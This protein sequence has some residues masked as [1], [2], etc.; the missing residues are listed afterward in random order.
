MASMISME[1]F[2]KCA[3]LAANGCD[4][5]PFLRLTPLLETVEYD[6]QRVYLFVSSTIGVPKTIDEAENL[7]RKRLVALTEKFGECLRLIDRPKMLDMRFLKEIEHQLPADIHRMFWKPWKDAR[8][9][10][11]PAQLQYELADII[12]IPWGAEFT[13]ERVGKKE[14]IK[15]LHFS[16]EATQLL[17]DLSQCG[18]CA[19]RLICTVQTGFLQEPHGPIERLMDYFSN[20]PDL[21]IKGQWAHKKAYRFNSENDWN[22]LEPITLQ[23][24]CSGRFSHLA[25]RYPNWDSQ[26]GIPDRMDAELLSDPSQAIV[27]ATSA[28]QIISEPIKT[29]SSPDGLRKVRLISGEIQINEDAI[30][31]VS[32]RIKAHLGDFEEKIRIFSWEELSKKTEISIRSLREALEAL[33]KYPGSLF[34]IIPIG[35]ED[36]GFEIIRYINGN[37]SKNKT[38]EI[39]LRDHLDFYDL[40]HSS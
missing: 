38:I 1:Q 30:H 20:L 32:K 6:G 28:N 36:E 7:F 2:S 17:W 31:V 24:L 22:N 26:L 29:L 40:R 9:D 12:G 18:L 37:A 3:Y 14:R 13:F 16:T 8:S 10:L 27:I 19:P 15:L 35:F 4:L 39:Y 21:W 23:D 34:R 33:D 11:K 25:Q 5:Q